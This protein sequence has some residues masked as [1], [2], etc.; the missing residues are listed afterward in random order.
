MSTAAAF[1]DSRLTELD[2][3][4]NEAQSG[5]LD[6][7]RCRTLLTELKLALA[8]GQLGASAAQ[9][10]EA[11]RLVHEA[12]V[13]LAVRTRDWTAFER[14]V[15]HLKPHYFPA[16][17][18]TSAAATAAPPPQASPP[19]KYV[20]LGLNL[21][22][23]LAQN[24]LAE[25]HMELELLTP[26]ER[27]GSEYIRFPARVE[28]YL[29]EGS[30][31]KIMRLEAGEEWAPFLELLRDTTRA[32]VA[33]CCAASYDELPLRDVCAML[34]LRGAG[35]ESSEREAATALDTYLRRRM[36]GGAVRHRVV[37]GGAGAAATTAA[38]TAAAAVVRFERDA[39][40]AAATDA[41]GRRVPVEET[42]A[43]TLDYARGLERIV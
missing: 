7:A 2:R 1:A 16:S 4:V 15:A 35:A 12:G 43:R 27:A 40:D 6:E 21:M 8:R 22:R 25:F 5:K 9:H 10:A 19:Y 3:H 17:A 38:A 18:A 33:E 36:A 23:L 41:A 39:V 28:Q 14:H 34:S 42:V 32:E 20:V 29:V 31:G 24:R 11:A 37:L 13:R 26:E 30:Y